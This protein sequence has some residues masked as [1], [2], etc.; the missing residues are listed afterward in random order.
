MRSDH[1]QLIGLYFGNYSCLRTGLLATGLAVTLTELG[2]SLSTG[3][4]LILRIPTLL[5]LLTF[6]SVDRR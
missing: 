2:Y 3:A 5:K 1:L 6:T 4:Q